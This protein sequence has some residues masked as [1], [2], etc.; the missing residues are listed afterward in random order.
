MYVYTQKHNGY[1]VHIC[2]HIYMHVIVVF[3][4][5]FSSMNACNQQEV[6]TKLYVA[7]G[8]TNVHIFGN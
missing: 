5:I 3:I 1:F 6:S 8:A 4:Y 7:L 2:T